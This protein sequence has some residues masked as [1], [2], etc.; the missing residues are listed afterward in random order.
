MPRKLKEFE[1]GHGFTKADWDE[2]SDNPELTDEELAQGRP[3]REVFPELAKS[4]DETLKRQRGKQKAPTKEL[5]SLRVD[6]DTLQAYRATGPGWQN[7]MT[8]ALRAQM[9]G[10]AKG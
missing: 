7:R 5:I 10:R 3:F 8:K 9:P 4:I 6:R 1:P 2:V